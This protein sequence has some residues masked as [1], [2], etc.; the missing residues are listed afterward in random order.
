MNRHIIIILSILMCTMLCVIHS[1]ADAKK[2]HKQKKK[3]TAFAQAGTFV[4]GGELSIA[5]LS[6]SQVEDKTELDDTTVDVSTFG[7]SPRVG[8][9]VFSNRKLA[10]EVAA[11]IGFGSSSSEQNGEEGASSSS[12]KAGLD[13]PLYLTMMRRKRIFPLI[14]FSYLRQSLT[15]K[16]NKDADEV[17]LGGSQLRFGAGLSF[18]LGNKNGGFA[19]VTIDYL[20]QDSLVDSEGNGNNQRGFDVGL[21]FGLF[22]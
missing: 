21:G 8:Y 12:W 14:H 1:N 4:I 7:L 22:F 2:R 17:E 11:Q 10:I 9:F 18:A 19:K 5:S 3:N 20:L 13:V 16:A 15:T 6:R